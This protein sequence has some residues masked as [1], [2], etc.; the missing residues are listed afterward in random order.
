MFCSLRLRISG[1]SAV[2]KKQTVPELRKC[3]RDLGLPSTGNK[4][5]L[6]KRL[7]GIIHCSENHTTTNCTQYFDAND[8]RI[9][10]SPNERNERTQEKTSISSRAS[11]PNSTVQARTSTPNDVQTEKTATE[12]AELR[13]QQ[14]EWTADRKRLVEEIAAMKR[15]Y[16]P[17]PALAGGD[18]GSAAPKVPTAPTVSF[19]NTTSTAP[20][21]SATTAPTT[22]SYTSMPYNRQQSH[23]ADY[24][25]QPQYNAAPYPYGMNMFQPQYASYANVQWPI[26]SPY[27]P[28]ATNVQWPT[29]TSYGASGEQL[30]YAPAAPLS[31]YQLPAVNGQPNFVGYNLQPQWRYDRMSVQQAAECLPVFDPDD[32]IYGSST[33]FIARVRSL[34]A[35]HGW[36]D[37]L[38]LF[39]AQL[40]LKGSA[41]AW[42]DVTNE[43][44]ATMANF[45]QTLIATFP[46]LTTA[47]DVQEELVRSTRANGETLTSFCHRMVV[48]GR[49]GAM[50]EATL[51]QHILKR[52]NHHE[53][54]VSVVNTTINTITELH[55]AVARFRHAFPDKQ[56][57][58][59]PKT[60]AKVLVVNEPNKKPTTE[61]KNNEP[62]QRRGARSFACYNCGD[63]GHR[64]KDCTQT[65]IKCENCHRH[66]HQTKDCRPEPVM[67][68]GAAVGSALR[69]DVQVG[70]RQMSG[71]VDG[72][73]VRS[74]VGKTAATEIGTIEPC[75]PLT[76]Q[77]FS[78][79]PICCDSKIIT[80]V[81]VD[82]ITYRG[83]IHL[84][85]DRHLGI[86]EVLL[87]TKLL[88][89]NGNRLIIGDDECF[90]LPLCDNDK[91]DDAP[92]NLELVLN[93]Y[94]QCFATDLKD[95]GTCKTAAMKIEV[96]TDKPVNL[97]PYRVPFPKQQVVN[98]MVND[99]IINGIITKSDSPYASPIVLVKKANGDDRM[100]ID[101]RALNEITFKIPFPMPII[102]DLL[103]KL[104]GNKYFTTLDLM[105]GYYQIPVHTDSRKY[106]AFVTQDG[107]FEFA[108]MPFGLVNAPSVFQSC[109][110]EIAR[111][112][113]PG[114]IITY[115]DDT[116]IP[117][118]TIDEGLA[119]LRRFL[120]VLSE[121][122]LTLRMDK[123]AFLKER[124]T[125]LGH[126][127]TGDGIEPGDLKVA[128]IRQFPA[129][130]NVHEVR[131]FLGLTG[132]F[133]KFVKN[134]STIAK[135][136][137]EL[138]K[139]KNA[140]KFVWADEQSTAFEML[141]NCLCS[142]PV[143]CLYDVNCRHEVHTDASIVGLAG[144]LMQEMSD[145][146]LHPVR[147][148]SRHCTST[149]SNYASHE[150]EVL[151]I[152]ESMERFR[153]YVL[154]KPVKVVTDCAAVTTTKSTKPLVSRIARWL[155]KL[156][157]YDIE[158]VH[159][160]GTQ[161]QYVDAMSRAPF[162]EPS[163]VTVVSERVMRID[164]D[165]SD[166][167]ITMQR[168]DPKLVRIFAVLKGELKNDDENQLRTDYEIESGRLYRKVNAKLKWVVPAAVRWRIVKSAHDDRGHFGLEKTLANIT[169]DFWFRRMRSYV[170]GYLA[171]CVECAYNKRPGGT[172]EGRLHVSA[173]IPIPFRTIHVD[174]LGPFPKSTKGNC[175]V[176]GIAD[177]FSK[178]VVIK[179]VK[180][181]NTKSVLIILNELTNYFGV[182]SRIVTDRGTAYSSKSF[183]DYCVKND[184]T[185][186]Q[187][188]VRTPRANGQIERVNQT[189][190]RYLRCVTLD[191]RK[192]DTSLNDLQWIVN[193]QVNKTNGCSP[194]EV[195]FRFKV[196]DRL[197]NKILD[198]LQE[199]GD[200]MEVE[201]NDSTLEEIATRADAEKM[202]WKQRY[203]SRHRTPKIYAEK[204]MV[205]IENVAPSTGDS[206]KLEPKYRG[207][208]EVKKV[209]DCDRYLIG[210]IDDAARTQRPFL[211]VF[212]SE[213]IKPWCTLGPE[214]EEDDED[215][216]SDAEQFNENDADMEAEG[217][218]GQE[219]PN[220]ESESTFE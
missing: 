174:H 112:L 215:D 190:N 21:T 111:K 48:I 211:S 159:R 153:V 179:P 2:M 210:D 213:K 20:R 39:S 67:V 77:G 140:P 154:G 148:F 177:S 214:C 32:A 85:E 73:S 29:Q 31:S 103:A 149:E 84:V 51:V 7:G 28:Y 13:R 61:K 143:L 128:A 182:P 123:C 87:G 74:L 46:D 36:D 24:C 53:F 208:Y 43:Q 200:E 47:A 44:F 189:I 55:A 129:P 30:P 156:Q 63:S 175:Y 104:A 144:V 82:G 3:L 130:T 41:R 107:H 168:Q 18:R 45:E 124:T 54:R 65:I 158:W 138:L 58:E 188:A 88:C 80:D 219:G 40:K 60:N 33:N 37:K 68:I 110:N 38:T 83:E 15:V 86:N 185:H 27:A 113:P 139:T 193:S 91:A 195:V 180:T 209:L 127:I 34:Q 72:G 95:I 11:S 10:K 64:L 122:G 35:Y 166:W 135:P 212:A 125:F 8:D 181:T 117:S 114:E 12:I 141:K 70:G 220:C 176:V 197:C 162:E 49:R 120:Q 99:L 169:K 76:I 198:V 106:T 217:G 16:Q 173:T 115:L 23:V 89:G 133:R 187:N 186:I 184:I 161:L 19:A 71:F 116:I 178:Y 42:N 78:A 14:I 167:L 134:Y 109:M 192:W 191:A 205:L 75:S 26:Q 216:G 201:D 4:A 199:E 164:I 101:Y 160:P 9:A 170:K 155:L 57:T 163:E 121:V 98:K 97:H 202:K 157:E 17:K 96:T 108:R 59:L 151:A 119:R 206:R 94:S 79:D 207:P 93:E 5:V 1:S 131:R 204:D 62:N 196:R 145:G 25:C 22:S 146:K 100:C 6:I 171:A 132:F 90:V 81:V 172:T 150:L 52:I 218:S 105:S 118:A 194:N 147:Y 126:I 136:I 203:D 56:R 69:K 183:A 137:T 142:E 92:D 165:Q 152:V 102:D 66:G 50:P